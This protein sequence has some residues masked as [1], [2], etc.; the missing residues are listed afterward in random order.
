MYAA[1]VFPPAEHHH[2]V[3]L[4]PEAAPYVIS[5]DGISKAFA[6]TGLRV[7]WG[8]GPPAVIARMKDFL[9]HVGAWAPRPEQVATTALLDDVEGMA[10][11]RTQMHDGIRSRLEALYRGFSDLERRGYPV[12]CV[13]PAGAIYLSLRMN[14]IG[15]SIGG[16]PIRTN[17]DIRAIM[18]ERAGLGVVPFQA[19]GLAQDT[20][21]FRLSVGAVSLADIEAAFPRVAS[22]LDQIA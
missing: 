6:A 7:G 16:V 5:L 2:P 18:L 21:W 10:T 20:G 11:Y 12:E 19:F 22:F 15:R 1:L 14:L 4:V 3:A 9:G 13:E 8:F 17:D